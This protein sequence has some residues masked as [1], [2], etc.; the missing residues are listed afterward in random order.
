MYRMAG[1]NAAHIV[2]GRFEFPLCAH[3]G[4]SSCEPR[5]RSPCSH[6]N[7]SAQCRHAL[8]AACRSAASPYG[9][10]VRGAAKSKRKGLGWGQSCR[11]S[12]IL[13]LAIITQS[14]PFAALGVGGRLRTGHMI[15]SG[16]PGLRVITL[17]EGDCLLAASENRAGVP[18]CD[19]R[20]VDENQPPLNA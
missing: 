5:A 2:R 1:A 16:W 12:D 8:L 6:C 3:N 19:R 4:Q 18:L 20:N 17:V 10:F 14:A 15:I 13:H 7:T 11:S 9:S